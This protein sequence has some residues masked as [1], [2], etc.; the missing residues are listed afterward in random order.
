MPKIKRHTKS[1]HASST[2]ATDGSYIVAMLGSEGLFAFDMK[3]TQLWKKDLGVLDSGWFMDKT[4]QWAFGSSPIIHEGTIILQADVQQGAF[5]GAFDLKTGNEKWRTPRADVP[6]WGTP[7]IVQVNGRPQIIV[8]GWKHIGAYDFATGKE[9]WKLA[10]GGDIPVPTPIV[11]DGLIYI[12]NAHGPMAPIYAIRT[13][14][15]GDISLK[16]RRDLERAHRLELSARR[17]LSHHPDPVSRHPVRDEEQ[18]RL[19]GA[20]CED[21][22]TDLPGSARERDDGLHRL[23]GGR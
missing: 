2:L 22:R 23:A 13:T 5:L 19:P 18:R 17:W 6:T 12:T 15:T 11:G 3:G 8:N 7:T 4:A 1:T 14:A 16:D 20:R 21:R 9:I 10:G